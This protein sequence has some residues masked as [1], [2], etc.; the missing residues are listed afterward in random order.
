MSSLEYTPQKYMLGEFNK[1]K[2]NY[3]K[4]HVKIR[5]VGERKKHVSDQNLKKGLR[6]LKKCVVFPQNQN[7][8][9]ALH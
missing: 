2:I 5:A 9:V 7:Q 3:I 6:N 4:V 1:R 8:T